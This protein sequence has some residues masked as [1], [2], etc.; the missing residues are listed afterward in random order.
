M[1]WLQTFTVGA[2]ACAEGGDVD[3]ASVGACLSSDEVLGASAGGA[4]GADDTADSADGFFARSV[5]DVDAIVASIFSSRCA[6]K[7]GLQQGE[8]GR[9]KRVTR[10][11]YS[12]Q[13]QSRVQAMP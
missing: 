2:F 11:L 5:S 9:A 3:V 1:R 6:Q 7:G 13:D 12:S 4:P 8:Q 10:T